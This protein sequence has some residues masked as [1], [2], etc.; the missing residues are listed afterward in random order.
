MRYLDQVR[1]QTQ[2]FVKNKVSHNYFT[3]ETEIP[4][5]ATLEEIEVLNAAND[6]V[7]SMAVSGSLKELHDRFAS[8]HEKAESDYIKT[9]DKIENIIAAVQSKEDQI[10]KSLDVEGLRLH[11]ETGLMSIFGGDT[12]LDNLAVLEKEGQT[13]AV[14]QLQALLGVQVEA[15]ANLVLLQTSYV[16]NVESDAA[17]QDDL[18]TF[19]SKYQ[20]LSAKASQSESSSSSDSK[21]L[22]SQL[23][24]ALNDINSSK[25]T[26]EDFNQASVQRNDV[27]QNYLS[28]TDSEYLDTFKNELL[29]HLALS[30]VVKESRQRYQ[31]E[32]FDRLLISAQNRS[33]AKKSN[34]LD[35]FCVEYVKVIEALID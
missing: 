34:S 16:E 22:D 7:K 17:A 27:F 18:A 10:Y 20:A 31:K 24:D 26:F 32:Q 8:L 6:E 9:R 30:I 35:D 33:L 2:K 1:E 28:N 15:F 11:D 4:L 13:A 23:G 3:G 5:T 29:H 12:S 19:T 21:I 25:K 14:Q